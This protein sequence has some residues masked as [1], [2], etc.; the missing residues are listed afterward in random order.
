MREFGSWFNDQGS[1]KEE[2]EI[3]EDGNANVMQDQF[4]DAE[5]NIWNLV[6]MDF[7]TIE[8][9]MKDVFESHK[10]G[11]ADSG[12]FS[13]NT[14]EPSNLQ[15]EVN[16]MINMLPDLTDT[17][18]HALLANLQKENESR[19]QKSYDYYNRMLSIESSE[20]YEGFIRIGSDHE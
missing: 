10:K 20:D 6:K 8:N 2:E 18:V 9:T 11:L 16:N 1:S 13:L 17:Q 7:T 19:K 5:G 15:Y 3:K 14:Q 4:L 12:S